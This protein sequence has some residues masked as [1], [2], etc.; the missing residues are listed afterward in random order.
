MSVADSS[1]LQSVQSETALPPRYSANVTKVTLHGRE[2]RKRQSDARRRIVDTSSIKAVIFTAYVAITQHCLEA[3]TNVSR[4]WPSP[5]RH[6][7]R[8]S[9]NPKSGGPRRTPVTSQHH[10]MWSISIAREISELVLQTAVCAI[11]IYHCYANDR[12]NTP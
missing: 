9:K 2:L 10:G 3:D 11:A 1:N 12:P 7:Q 5:P 8:G 4:A 6:L